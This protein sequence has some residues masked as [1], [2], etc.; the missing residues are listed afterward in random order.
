MYIYIYNIYIYILY[1]MVTHTL[2][3]PLD[4]T[5]IRVSDHGI[6]F[7]EPS[8]RISYNV[9]PPIISWLIS[10]SNYSYKHHKA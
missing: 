3:N 1:Y 4:P 2:Q 8:G 6:L 10:H 5:Q 7:D 9:A